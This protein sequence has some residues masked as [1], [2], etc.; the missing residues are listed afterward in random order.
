MIH[1]QRFE[2]IISNAFVVY[3]KRYE[4]PFSII[5]K[6]ADRKIIRTWYR[7]YLL[8]KTREIRKEISGDQESVD[9]R[10]CGRISLVALGPVTPFQWKICKVKSFHIVL[11][12]FGK[13]TLSCEPVHSNCLRVI[14]KSPPMI[15][16]LP[17]V[18]FHNRE[19]SVSFPLQ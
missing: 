1:H 3:P 16:F 5:H 12:I 11:Q 17:Q 2:F 10:E 14:L 7:K 8:A 4:V 6:K 15:S 18:L 19:L 13:A 9:S